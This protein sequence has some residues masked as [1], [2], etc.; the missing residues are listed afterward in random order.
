MGLVVHCIMAFSL[1]TDWKVIR[2]IN[3]YVDRWLKIPKV[4]LCVTQ[5]YFHYTSPISNHSHCSLQVK[6]VIDI[7]LPILFES[8]Q[9]CVMK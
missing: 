3:I 4:L 6:D 7:C 1:I 9:M 8:N 2:I 5:L